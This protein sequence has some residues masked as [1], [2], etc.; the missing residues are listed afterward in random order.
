MAGHNFRQNS[1]G[2]INSSHPWSTG[3]P[4]CCWAAHWVGRMMN[5]LGGWTRSRASI[6]VNQ[7]GNKSN[8]PASA[9][10]RQPM[11]IGVV[12]ISCIF[13]DCRGDRVLFLPREREV[14]VSSLGS[15]LKRKDMT[16]RRARSET[17]R[18]RRGGLYPEAVAGARMQTGRENV[19]NCVFSQY[20]VREKSG[21]SSSHDSITAV[22]A[23]EKPILPRQKSGRRPFGGLERAEKDSRFAIQAFRSPLRGRC[24]RGRA[25]SH[26]QG[27]IA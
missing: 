21:Q 27:A 6:A 7:S 20:L 2:K 26:S 3:A 15:L 4:G 22:A 11:E 17:E 1:N 19:D 23:L 18:G 16:R 25:A 9:G 8:I 14:E 5:G 13:L 10:V 24:G 12:A